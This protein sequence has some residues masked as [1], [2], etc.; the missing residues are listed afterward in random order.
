MT[1]Y[2]TTSCCGP[3]SV[4]VA[5]RVDRSYHHSYSKLQNA[6]GTTPLVQWLVLFKSVFA[7]CG[8]SSTRLHFLSG[9]T[10]ALKWQVVKIHDIF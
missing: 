6:Y 10:H 4:C 5:L 8:S 7:R 2:Y 1:P 9:S 3:S